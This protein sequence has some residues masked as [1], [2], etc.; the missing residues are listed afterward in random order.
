[1]KKQSQNADGYTLLELIITLTVL[2]IL[3][4][5]TIPL[6]QNA[7]KRQKELRLRETLREIRASID[8][9]KR[10]TLGA[11]PQGAITTTN[12]SL[13]RGQGQIPIPDPRSRVMIDDCEI[14]DT[15]NLDRFPPSLENLVD[16]VK[17]KSR[18]INAAQQQGGAF[19]DKNATDINEEKDIIKV[20]LR[21]LPID[22]IT[23]ESDWKLRSSYQAKDEENW[24]SIN[25]FD[26]RS[27]SDEEALNGEKYSDW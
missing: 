18:G 5:G 8:E 25:V 20:Y 9:F 19:T 2:A 10:D 14:F 6:A 15:E 16:G 21:E 7:V 17:I 4:M 11:C 27:N 3:V 24:D 23:G 26:V 12:Q 13:G 1:M 22:P